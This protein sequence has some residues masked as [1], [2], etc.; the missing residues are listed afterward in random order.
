MV[1]PLLDFIATG[2]HSRDGV[3]S[4]LMSDWKAVES[5]DI[6]QWMPPWMAMRLAISQNQNKRPPKGNEGGKK[7]PP[8]KKRRQKRN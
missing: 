4:V 8:G 6:S 1:A 5:K 3:H 2:A 7:Q